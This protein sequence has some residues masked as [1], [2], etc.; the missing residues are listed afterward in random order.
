MLKKLFKNGVK[1]SQ[2]LPKNEKSVSN[3]RVQVVAYEHN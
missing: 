3:R 2:K 1:G